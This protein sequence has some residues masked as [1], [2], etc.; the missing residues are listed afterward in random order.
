MSTTI[1]PE[2][3]TFNYEAMFLLSQSQA[4]DFGAAIAHIKDGLERSGAQII[5]MKKWDERRL[6]YE[7]NKNKRG[8]YILCYFSCNARKMVEIERFFNLSE[9]VMRHLMVRVDHLSLDEM[10][11]ADG[12]KE[13]ETE[14]KLRAERP[15]R[16]EG[17]APAAAAPAAAPA[18]AAPATGA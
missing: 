3:R 16:P 4:A 6:A 5:A 13:L 8:V 14:A 9:K 12:Q 1:T 15:A 10:Q 18:P 2:V 7:I 11:A 17:E